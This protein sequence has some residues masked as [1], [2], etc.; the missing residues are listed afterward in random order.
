MKDPRAS[1]DQQTAREL[2]L[3]LIQ[4]ALQWIKSDRLVILPHDDLHY[5]PF[6]ALIDPANGRA[7]GERFAL[8]YAPSAD[9]LLRLKRVDNLRAGRLLA[10]AD[11]GMAEAQREVAAI[12]KL[13]PQ[14]ARLIS[15]PL[16]KEGELKR[17]VGAYDLIH[18]SV[19][20]RFV[21]QEPL[22]SHLKLAPHDN[23]DG[24]LTAAEMFGLPL[25]NARLVLLSACETGQA[26]ATRANEL[27]GMQRALLYAGAQSLALSAW[28]VDA[29]ATALWME[30][31][32]RTAQSQP[33]AAAARAALIAV[34][35]DARYAH[36]YRTFGA[37]S[38]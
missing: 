33:P 16:V 24:Q 37:H 7:L 29:A 5:L 23:E 32:Y 35:Q 22:L 21:A 28:E 30:T 9:V 20:G 13:Y 25:Q 15:N 4:P 34:K 6:Q 19:H 38:S 14:G 12:G 31:F 11:P 8:S 27:L 36:P 10:V 17:M 2:F 1:F 3:L 18:L 26:Q